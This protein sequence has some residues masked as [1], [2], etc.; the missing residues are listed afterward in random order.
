MRAQP[1]VL[2]KHS[3]AVRRQAEAVRRKADRL[4]EESRRVRAELNSLRSACEH[5]FVATNGRPMTDEERR[6]FFNGINH[7]G[8]AGDL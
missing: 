5:L 3:A 8:I 4:L 1:Y 2:R 7:T 6:K